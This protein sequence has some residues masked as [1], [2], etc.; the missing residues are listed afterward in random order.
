MYNNNEKLWAVSWIGERRGILV[1]GRVWRKVREGGDD[2]IIWATWNPIPAGQFVS[3]KHN[4][5]LALYFKL[6]GHIY[7]F[8]IYMYL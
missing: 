1:Y 7:I 3:P 5:I 6:V 4:F 2:I 8:N